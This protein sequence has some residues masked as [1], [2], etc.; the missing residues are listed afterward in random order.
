MM[1]LYENVIGQTKNALLKLYGIGSEYVY[2]W[3][4]A[5]LV[6]FDQTIIK[7]FVSEHNRGTVPGSEEL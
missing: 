6:P 7:S 3:N 5:T 1:C 2:H 4:T